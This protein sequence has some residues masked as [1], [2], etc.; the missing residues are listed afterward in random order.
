MATKV[1]AFKKDGTVQ[2]VKLVEEAGDSLLSQFNGTLTNNILTLNNGMKLE[3]LLNDA[4]ASFANLATTGI[5]LCYYDTSSPYITLRSSNNKDFTATYTGSSTGISWESEN[6]MYIT[7]VFWYVPGYGNIEVNITL[8]GVTYGF[9]RTTIIEQSNLSLLIPRSGDA[10]EI[11]LS[12]RV[13][14]ATVRMCKD[15]TLK[16]KELIEESATSNVAG[17]NGKVVNNTLVLNNGYKIAFTS[18]STFSSSVAKSTIPSN[19]ISVNFYIYNSSQTSSPSGFQLSRVS[20]TNNFTAELIND[21]VKTNYNYKGPIRFGF[22]DA[23][24]EE[25]SSGY[26]YSYFPVGTTWFSFYNSKNELMFYSPV[27]SRE[28]GEIILNNETFI[29]LVPY[30]D[31]FTLPTVR[32]YKDGTIRCAEVEEATVT[33]LKSNWG[34]PTKTSGKA[35]FTF[36]NGYVLTLRRKGSNAIMSLAD[37]AVY[38]FRMSTSS[39]LACMV[40]YKNTTTSQTTVPNYTIYDAFFEEG[41]S[42]AYCAC[43]NPNM[44]FSGVYYLELLNSKGDIVGSLSN[45]SSSSSYLFFAG[46]AFDVPI[47]DK[48]SYSWP[49]STPSVTTGNNLITSDGE[50]FL[51]NTGDQ[52]MVR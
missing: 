28:Y 14:P 1:G 52:F 15:G 39:G 31:R 7:G 38:A 13:K 51:T 49:G 23:Y 41:N 9:S 36:P 34:T 37:N 50:T 10:I 35:E 25:T 19:V 12:M 3:F 11:P 26:D 22:Y 43:T 5:Q 29:N 42:I 18:G 48:I 8:N 16:C 30:E 40:L 24:V 27:Y 33:Q 17:F 47:F 2:C 4:P 32:V 45:E 21:N 46:T 20:G 44:S 6:P